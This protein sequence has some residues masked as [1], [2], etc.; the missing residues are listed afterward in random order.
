MSC[1]GNLIIG[2][3]VHDSGVAEHIPGRAEMVPGLAVQTFG[4][5][6]PTAGMAVKHFRPPQNLWRLAEFSPGRAET[7]PGRAVQPVSPIP[8]PSGRAVRNSRPS[9]NGPG[10]AEK[11][12]GVAVQ[13]FRGP[14]RLLGRP[15][16]LLGWPKNILGQPREVFGGPSISVSRTKPV[17]CR[18][19]WRATVPRGRIRNDRTDGR[20]PSR[21]SPGSARPSSKQIRTQPEP[22]LYL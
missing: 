11:H 5:A 9:Q 1:T 18:L 20:E 13:T 19:P 16:N 22:S 12:F 4:E 14:S 8:M 15:S 21:L 7:V 17:G 10:R 3:A 6:V 2:R